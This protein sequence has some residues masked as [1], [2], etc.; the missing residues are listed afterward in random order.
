MINV[1]NIYYNKTYEGKALSNTNS[2]FEP[3]IC[4]YDCVTLK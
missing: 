2:A 4:I 1:I 3:N